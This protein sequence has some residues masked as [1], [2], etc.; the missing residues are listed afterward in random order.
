MWLVISNATFLSAQQISANTQ[1][2]CMQSAARFPL[3]KGAA[4]IFHRE[5]KDC[6]V[7]LLRDEGRKEE[8]RLDLKARTTQRHLI[9]CRFK[10]YI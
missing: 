4:A 6:V 10:A 2:G 3:A 9:N 1:T 7:T 8:E 5:R